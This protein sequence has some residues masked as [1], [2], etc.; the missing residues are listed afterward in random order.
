MKRLED[1]RKILEDRHRRAA[2]RQ[3]RNAERTHP[4]SRGEREPAPVI[5]LP[6]K[7]DHGDAAS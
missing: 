5:P 2:E 6:V 3:R 1:R 7:E 4:S